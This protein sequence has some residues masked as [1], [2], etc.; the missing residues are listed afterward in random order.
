M[1][2]KKEF[3]SIA[4]NKQRVVEFVFLICIKFKD[5]NFYTF[6]NK[7]DFD[8]YDFIFIIMKRN[9]VKY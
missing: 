7:E 4:K 9:L 8:S 2:I 6:L 3:F 5:L 1:N